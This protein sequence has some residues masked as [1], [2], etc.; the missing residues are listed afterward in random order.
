MD[1]S[2][3]GR[4]SLLFLVL[5]RHHWSLCPYHA[6]ASMLALALVQQDYV[7]GGGTVGARK[8][9]VTHAN[10]VIGEVT[11]TDPATHLAQGEAAEFSAPKFSG[12]H[13]IR[14][15]VSN[16]ASEH[17]D[18]QCQWLLPRGGWTMEQMQTLFFYVTGTVKTDVRV[19]RAVAGW[20]SLRGGGHCP[21]LDSIPLA[22][23]DEFKTFVNCL[24]MHFSGIAGDEMP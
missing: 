14:H 12:T 17:Y 1:R 2:K 22:S 11:T 8:S 21:S 18:M 5:H 23:Q 13:A 6:L 10:K 19:A 15:G 9:L 24:F 16:E 20:P 7:F 4:Q 3:V